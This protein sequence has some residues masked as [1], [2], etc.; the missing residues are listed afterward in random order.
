MNTLLTYSDVPYRAVSWSGVA[1][2]V[3][4]LAYLVLIVGQYLIVGRRAPVG[5]H[6]DPHRAAAALGRGARVPRRAR[7]VSLPDLPGGARTARAI[8]VAREAGKGL[9]DELADGD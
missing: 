2:V 9:R 3:A 6:A 5:H 4:S 7:R 1:L 8:H